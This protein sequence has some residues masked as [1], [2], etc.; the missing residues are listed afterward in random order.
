MLTMCFGAFLL[1]IVFVYISLKLIQTN[2]EIYGKINGKHSTPSW[3]STWEMSWSFVHY[4][5][6]KF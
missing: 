5:K 6:G 3:V 4:L 1:E 2:R